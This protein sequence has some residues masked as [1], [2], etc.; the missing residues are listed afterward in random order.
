MSKMWI[1]NE[2]MKGGLAMSNK[3]K[4]RSNKNAKGEPLF[5]CPFP[6]CGQIFAKE[7]GK[8]ETCLKHRKLIADVMFILDHTKPPEKVEEP[9]EDGPKLF[10]PRPGMSIQAIQQAA[11]AAKKGV[12][13]P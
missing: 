12:S 5:R 11:E 8:P 7:P 1:R 10:I 6:D 4:L 3:I 2:S 9:E 13:K